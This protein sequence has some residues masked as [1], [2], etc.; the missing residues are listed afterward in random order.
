MA[1]DLQHVRRNRTHLDVLMATGR[2]G[3]LPHLP[4]YRRRD[5]R[6]PAAGHAVAEGEA[7]VTEPVAIYDGTEVTCPVAGGNWWAKC[8]ACMHRTRPKRGTIPWDALAK[9]SIRCAADG[10]TLRE[11]CAQMRLRGGLGGIFGLRWSGVAEIVGCSERT[12]RE[13]CRGEYEKL[14]KGDL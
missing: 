10:Y 2:G 11:W 14:L 5:H 9:E 12:V 3:T 7:I 13:Q 6:V 4:R 8:C 1:S